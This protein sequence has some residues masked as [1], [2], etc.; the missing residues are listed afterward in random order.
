ERNALRRSS[1]EDDVYQA[2]ALLAASQAVAIGMTY[3]G[4]QRDALAG[5]TAAGSARNRRRF[6]EPDRLP[7]SSR[8][9]GRNRGHGCASSNR[10]GAAG[11]NLVE[12]HDPN[13]FKS[14]P[15]AVLERDSGKME[16]CIY[17]SRSEARS[18]PSV[19]RPAH[20][21]YSRSKGLNPRKGTHSWEV[22]EPPNPGN[23]GPCSDGPK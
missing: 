1:D 19:D 15:V 4:Q 6:R 21:S 9:G 16:R 11:T 8:R 14:A 2:L 12:T 7:S 22:F 3:R 13:R 17:P 10:A 23:F 5:R 20:P 18:G